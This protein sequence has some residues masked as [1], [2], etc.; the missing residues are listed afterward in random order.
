MSTQTAPVPKKKKERKP[1]TPEEYDHQRSQFVASGPTINTSEWLYQAVENTELDEKVKHER[2]MILHA[3]ER[4]FYLKDYVRCMELIARGLAI[5]NVQD[6]STKE[7]KSKEF[8]GI[9]I[10]KTAKIEKHIL[11]LLYIKEKCEERLKALEEHS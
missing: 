8:E 11:E 9:K 3:C 10:H 5:F 1:Q 7:E 6:S 4:A 2:L